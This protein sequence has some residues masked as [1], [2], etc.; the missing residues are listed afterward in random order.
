MCSM[1]ITTA[2]SASSLELT[3]R[4]QKEKRTQC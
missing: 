2:F 4:E 1:I 3:L